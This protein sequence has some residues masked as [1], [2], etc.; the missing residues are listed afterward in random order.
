PDVLIA[1]LRQT[2]AGLFGVVVARRVGGGQPVGRGV[3]EHLINRYAVFF[4]GVAHPVEVVVH[5]LLVDLAADLGRNAVEVAQL[6][7]M[8]RDEAVTFG[9]AQRVPPFL[10]VVGIGVAGRQL[11][12]IP[13][14]ARRGG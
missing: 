4:G 6:R 12:R 8:R 10:D 3:F 13:E 2:F 1:R 7:R 9:L 5:H 14:G 11:A